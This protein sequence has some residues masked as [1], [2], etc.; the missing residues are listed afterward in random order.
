MHA[1]ET[2]GWLK[3]EVK[4]VPHKLGRH[5]LTHVTVASTGT[6][7]RVR[8]TPDA[9]AAGF[10]ISV[11]RR[12]DVTIERAGR[13]EHEVAFDTDERDVGPLRA[14]AAKVEAAVDGLRGSRGALLS[15]MLDG[16][17][18]ATH[19]HPAAMVERLVAAMA[20]VVT[21]IARHSL[22]PRELVLKRLLG[23][24]RREEIFLSRSELE[25]K[26]QALPPKAQRVFVPLGLVEAAVVESR[27]VE[28]ELDDAPVRPM[29]AIGEA[30]VSEP[31]GA[32]VMGT[33]V[34]RAS[35]T[36]APAP[37]EKPMAFVIEAE[38]PPFPQT[39]PTGVPT[40][41]AT[42]AA[43]AASAP[44][45]TPEPTV[46]VAPPA[47]AA[48]PEELQ[49]AITLEAELPPT[50]VRP[51]SLPSLPPVSSTPPARAKG[52]TVPPPPPPPARLS[53]AATEAA[54]DA[55]LRDLDD[56]EPTQVVTS[57]PRPGQ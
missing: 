39:P 43:A 20:P 18:L 12:G 48:Q 57:A 44:P 40:S 23:G 4:M 42:A 2:A 33:T 21:E 14:F 22:S 10:D 53:A 26:V 6:V 28:V 32:V 56:A 50:R 27:D 45:P 7:M 15:A 47:Q 36:S 1:P 19:E 34:A 54:V 9:T 25:K 41:V 46:V 38:A 35:T 49:P 3:K 52:K 8:A 5:H 11:G 16:K 13:N 31:M 55:A 24:D 37:V 51:A 29:A 30:E 17:A